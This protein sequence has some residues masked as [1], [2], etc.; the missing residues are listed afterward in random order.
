MGDLP[1]VGD[2][3]YHH[4]QFILLLV[5]FQQEVTLDLVVLPTVCKL[6]FLV[7]LVVS[8]TE[9]LVSI[10]PYLKMLSGHK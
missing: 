9:R 4:Y 5:V 6:L 10:Q 1:V 8:Y 2:P 3:P 7:V